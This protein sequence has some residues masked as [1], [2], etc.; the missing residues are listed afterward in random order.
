M[1]INIDFTP[2]KKALRF[3]RM[4]E[5]TEILDPVRKKFLVL[6]P[7]DL[8]RQLVVQYLTTEKKI[9]PQ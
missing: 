1:L 4:G 6:Q 8:V 3:K 5:R 7:E 9:P 2:F